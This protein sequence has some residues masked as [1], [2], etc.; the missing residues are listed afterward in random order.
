MYAYSGSSGSVLVFHAAC[1]GPPIN[2]LRSVSHDVF[3]E[4]ELKSTSTQSAESAFS[5]G[6]ISTGNALP[7]LLIQSASAVTVNLY[8]P[9]P[10]SLTEYETA[11]ERAPSASTMYPRGMT[12]TV[13]SSVGS[14]IRTE[15]SPHTAA[16]RLLSDIVN[17]YK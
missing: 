8:F 17:V 3:G 1:H 9:L 10:R 2:S 7:S 14:Y 13:S 11:S 12:Y 5:D 4:S 6:S 16:V 15:P